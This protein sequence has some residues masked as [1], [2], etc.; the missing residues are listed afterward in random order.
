VANFEIE[1]VVGDDASKDGTVNVISSLNPPSGFRLK[2]IRQDSNLGML[3]N[4][5]STLS[6]C[7]GQYIALLEGDDY[8]I[9]S[10]KL[11]RQV[12]FL[13]GNPDFSICYHPV[14]IDKGIDRLLNDSEVVERDVSDIYDLAKGNFMHT[15][16]VVFRANL[17]QKFPENFFSSTV[18]DYFLHMLNARHGK[19]K[20]IP[21]AMGVYRIHEGGVWSLQPNMDLKILTYLEAMMGCFEPDVE[22]I[23]KARHKKIAAKSFFSRMSEEGFEQRLQR[24]CMFGTDVFQAELSDRLS[25]VENLSVRAGLKNVVRRFFPGL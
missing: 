3:P 12:D 16:S 21:V 11:Q 15:C 4:F 22:A 10:V 1:L 17:F 2:I 25:D 24:C 5:F 8:W 18:G 6:Q 23:L 14:K 19:I 13:E 20:K 7:S 9:D